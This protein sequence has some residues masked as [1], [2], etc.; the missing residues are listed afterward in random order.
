LTEHSV[1]LAKHLEAPI[2]LSSRIIG[3]EGR[4][5]REFQH[6]E[7]FTNLLSGHH[8]WPSD[9]VDGA[10]VNAIWQH[11]YTILHTHIAHS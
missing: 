8:H 2:D 6:L 11:L 9:V 7:T 4:I 1:K 3:W 5:V 10:S